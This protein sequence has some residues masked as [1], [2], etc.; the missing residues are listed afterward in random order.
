MA[1]RSLVQGLR[2]LLGLRVVV[3][4]ASNHI[5]YTRQES[6]LGGGTKETR[7][8][9]LDPNVFRTPVDVV[10]VNL[11]AP[12]P[13]EWHSWL[14]GGDL[15]DVNDNDRSV[16]PGTNDQRHPRDTHP[17]KERREG[18]PKAALDR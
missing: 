10:D 16:F 14:L 4:R 9:E 12:I 17:S 15:P 1:S 6:A 13:A 18:T 7:C 2:K 3:G 8:V 11:K 5:F